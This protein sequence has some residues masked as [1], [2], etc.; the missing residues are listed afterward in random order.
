MPPK[1][2]KQHAAYDREQDP[3]RLWVCEVCRSVHEGVSPP[4]VCRCG[5]E[6]FESMADRLA[7]EHALN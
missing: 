4:D 7:E 1:P 2:K 6:Y 5:H 3:T